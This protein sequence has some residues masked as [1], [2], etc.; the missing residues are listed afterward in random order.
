ML[1]RS[2]EL[3]NIFDDLQ[4]GT[5]ARPPPQCYQVH[6][7]LIDRYFDLL[8]GALKYNCRRAAES[9]NIELESQLF[10]YKAYEGNRNKFP[11]SSYVPVTYCF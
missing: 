10:D 9:R 5:F 11:F 7:Q 4:E 1:S 6:G 8:M 3:R 2:E